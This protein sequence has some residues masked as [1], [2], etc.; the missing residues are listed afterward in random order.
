MRF[1]HGEKRCDTNSC[2]D[3]DDSKYCASI[4]RKCACRAANVERIADLGEIVQMCRALTVRRASNRQAIRGGLFIIVRQAPR[5]RN[6]PPRGC[7][8]AYRE[9]LASPILRQRLAVL[10]AQCKGPDIRSFI[11]NVAHDKRPPSLP[12]TLCATSA[13]CE[14]GYSIAQHGRRLITQP[15]CRQRTL[16]PLDVD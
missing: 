12:S 4:E 16:Q 10:R 8:Q 9:K 11:N 7:L 6:V 1:Q 2:A 3:E 14:M 13:V 5:T 15:R